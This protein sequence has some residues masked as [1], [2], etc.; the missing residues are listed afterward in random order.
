MIGHLKAL[1]KYGTKAHIRRTIEAP[2][3]EVKLQHLHKL[4]RSSSQQIVMMIIVLFMNAFMFIL[5]NELFYKESPKMDISSFAPYFYAVMIPVTMYVLFHI[6]VNATR[7]K[8][9]NHLLSE[10]EDGKTL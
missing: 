7:F 3:H 9:A 8:L 5:S 1:Y 6:I 10:V 4:I 2:S